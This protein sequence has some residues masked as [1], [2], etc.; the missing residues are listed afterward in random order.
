MRIA[1]KTKRLPQ[2]GVFHGASGTQRVPEALTARMMFERDDLATNKVNVPPE[3][4]SYARMNSSSIMS[5][6]GG[7][8][9][10]WTQSLNL[11]KAIT[12]QRGPLKG[13]LPGSKIFP[14]MDKAETTSG[15]KLGASKLKEDELSEK[16]WIKKAISNPEHKGFC[17]PMTKSTCTPRRK[18]LA[19]RFKKGDIHADNEKAD[20]A[21][22]TEVVNQ[23]LDD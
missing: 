11:R 10:K 19:M 12:N 3:T 17:S 21:K 8:A 14:A 15:S 4:K 13:G 18:A 6:P 22:A 2:N 20:E 23:L 1:P 9:K 5:Q 7:T 16:D